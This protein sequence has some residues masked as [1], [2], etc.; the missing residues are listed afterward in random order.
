M[1]FFSNFLRDLPVYLLSLPVLLM[2]FSVHESAH[3]L[4]SIP[5]WGSPTARNLGRVT[6]AIRCERLDPLG[7]ICH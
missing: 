6:P 7:T 5:S 2:A 3:G 4:M 1:T